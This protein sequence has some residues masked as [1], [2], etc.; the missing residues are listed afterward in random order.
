MRHARL[1]IAASTSAGC[2]VADRF[3]AV[4]PEPGEVDR[5]LD[6]PAALTDARMKGSDGV[7]P[8]LVDVDA[9]AGLVVLDPLEPD[10][11]VPPCPRSAR[12]LDV[13]DTH[14]PDAPLA[15]ADAH[16]FALGRAA[17]QDAQVGLGR[18]R[19]AGP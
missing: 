16:V 18:R 7:G 4:A 10:D 1:R 5:P 15:H 9:V 6:F 8:A 12:R 17:L 13:G 19:V 11:R 3:A 14:V 2:R